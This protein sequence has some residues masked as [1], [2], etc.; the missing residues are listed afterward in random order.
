MAS[1]GC[2]VRGSQ[3]TL[4]FQSSIPVSTDSR[5][6]EHFQQMRTL[7]SGFLQQKSTSERQ[8]FYD[9]VASKTDKMSPEEYESFKIQV[10]CA[11]QNVKSTSSRQVLPKR[12]A[13]VTTESQ[14]VGILP[15]ATQSSTSSQMTADSS[16]SYS[17]YYTPST[18]GVGNPPSV[19]LQV[20]DEGS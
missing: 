3:T 4:P 2:S 9:Y 6:I 12:S 18:I 11:I 1:L 20:A 19:N 7:I 17:V 13:S 14:K 10:F 16:S 15:P 8:P 5:I